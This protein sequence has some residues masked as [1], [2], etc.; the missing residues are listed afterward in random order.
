MT[1]ENAAAHCAEPARSPG[2]V[3]LTGITR[4]TVVHRVPSAVGWATQHTPETGYTSS[5][6]AMD[7][8]IPPHWRVSG[9]S[10][11]AAFCSGPFETGR[12]AASRTR[13]GSFGTSGRH[14]AAAA[15]S[16]AGAG[17]STAE[18]AP[19]R[20]LVGPVDGSAFDGANPPSS[21]ALSAPTPSATGSAPRVARRAARRVVGSGATY[22]CT[23]EQVSVRWMPGT[24]WTLL[25]I[26]VP[27]SS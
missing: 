15:G 23:T 11:Y 2:T 7:G 5:V 4:S 24:A 20:A 3:T 18:V 17:T 21:H 8:A 6:G 19:G 1:G 12:R 22:R 25:T 27:R 13:S 26:I 10:P 9:G 16:R 14:V